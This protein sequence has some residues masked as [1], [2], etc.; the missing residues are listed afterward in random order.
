MKY[1]RFNPFCG[2]NYDYSKKN[3]ECKVYFG[4]FGA[5]KRYK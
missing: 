5:A 1:K 2:T 4:L 3:S